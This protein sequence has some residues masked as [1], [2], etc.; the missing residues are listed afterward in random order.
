MKSLTAILLLGLV[1]S[2]H[3]MAQS[4]IKVVCI[5]NSITEGWGLTNPLTEAYPVQLANL[6]GSTYEVLNCGV[7]A[8][9]MLKHGDVPYWNEAKYTQAKNYNPD[10]VIISLGTNDSKPQNW[11]YKKEYYNDYATMI[12]EFRKNGKNP[13][14]FVC[15]PPPAF[16]DNYGI[17]DYIIRDEMQPLIDSL[18]TT[19]RTSKID[20]F[21]G[22]LTTGNTFADGIHPNKD[23][24]LVMA[25]IA[26]EA[27]TR[28]M[29]VTAVKSPVSNYRLTSSEKITIAL[30]NNNDITLRNVP[31]A[32]KIN[33]GTEVKEIIDTI[34][35]N[36]EIQYTFNQKADLSQPKEYVISVYTAI[37]TDIPNDTLEVKTINANQKTDLALFFSGD[38]GRVK[39]PHSQAIMPTTAL[40]VE[41]WIYPTAFKKNYADGTILSKEQGTKGYL[42]S[43][44]GD[45]QARFVIYDGAIKQALAPTGSLKLNQ[46]QHLAG[47]YQGNII[48]LYL[49]GKLLA[50]TTTGAI[51]ESTAELTLGQTSTAGVDRSFIGGLD[52]VR[53]WNKALTLEQIEEQRNHQLWGNELGLAAYYKM[54]DG[55]GS[56]TASDST[57]TGKTGQMN[58]IEIDHSWMSGKGLVAKTGMRPTDISMVSLVGPSNKKGLTSSENITIKVLNFSETELSNVPVSYKIDDQPVVSETIAKMGPRECIDYTFT[59]K[60]DLS[61]YKSFTITAFSSL[62][63]DHIFQ[64]DTTLGHVTNFDPL[65]DNALIVSGV[66]NG[67][68]T[69]AHNSSLMPT[70]AFTLEAWIYPTQFKTNIWEGSVISK[71]S[72]DGG[73]AINIGGN[74]QGRIVIGSNNWY[75]AIIPAKTIVINKWTHIAGVYDGTSIKIYVNGELKGTKIGVGAIKASESP[76]YIG[77]SPVFSGREFKGGIDE[78]RIWNKAL[79]AG[80]VK[81]F[82]DFTLKGNEPGLVAYYKMNEVA[83]TTEVVD[84]SGQGNTGIVTYLDVKSCWMKGV[85]LTAQLDLTGVQTLKNKMDISI[86]PNPTSDYIFVKLN[87]RN[88]NVCITLTDLSGKVLIKENYLA[89]GQEIQVDLQKFSKGIFIITFQIGIDIYSVKA[90]VK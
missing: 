41:A 39:I 20:F 21:H 84:S 48:K 56:T 82:K 52:E 54:N 25:K 68:L 87:N 9:T 15:I 2:V 71:E 74:G 72:G 11:E 27:I 64:N 86:Y 67:R 19:L 6:L 3:S 1:L 73:Y 14:I 75:E 79:T 53:I 26:K 5:G 55:F 61:L 66:D 65:T 18:C 28:P 88:E 78:V 42:M 51:K 58:N 62:Q 80:E 59:K 35:A 34:P 8:R 23:G 60:A 90:T 33:G 50:T 12:G 43:V 29:T 69:I 44:G 85:G 57:G 22:L 38:N 31:I 81:T 37:A 70:K 89:E 47:V 4:P 40:T 63:S 46:W 77:A 30:N 36:R 24:A 16:I 83:G 10:I 45:G 76:I 7:S 13:Q 32:Y 49:D 17:R